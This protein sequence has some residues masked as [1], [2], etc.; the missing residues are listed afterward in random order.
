LK[1]LA[2]ILFLALVLVQSSGYIAF[3]KMQ[4]FYLKNQIKSKIKQGIPESELIKF[5]IN[6]EIENDIEWIHSKEFRYKGEMYDVIRKSEDSG[7]TIYYVIH[8][9]KETGLFVNLEKFVAQEKQNDPLQ[10]RILLDIDRILKLIYIQE[11]ISDNLI[12]KISKIKIF[13][14]YL[15]LINSYY[16]PETPPPKIV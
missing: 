16:K 13:D 12:I 14:H 15:D 2:S 11:Y 8:D 6:T 4:E 10:K 1:K 3:F 9:P 5:T 7:S